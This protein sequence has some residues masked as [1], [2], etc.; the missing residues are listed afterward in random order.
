MHTLPN[1]MMMKVI[2][3][4]IFYS[5]FQIEGLDS[6]FREVA[7]QESL[8]KSLLANVSYGESFIDKLDADFSKYNAIILAYDYAYYGTIQ[9]AGSFSFYAALP[10]QK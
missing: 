6:D 3:F 2:L 1:V 5:D 9:S 4:V 10:Y 7:F 8:N